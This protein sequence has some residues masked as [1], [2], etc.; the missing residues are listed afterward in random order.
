[1]VGR[2]EVLK[3]GR[4]IA[5]IDKCGTFIGEM[6]TLLNTSRTA[7]IRARE[8]SIVLELTESTFRTFLQEVPEM[9]WHLAVTLAQRLELTNR[10]L[11]DALGK[12]QVV[13]DHFRVVRREI[14]E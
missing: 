3:A 1:M 4:T 11:K 5:L 7:T 12:L 6:S 10:S 13:K 8:Q 9:A 14:G 2:L